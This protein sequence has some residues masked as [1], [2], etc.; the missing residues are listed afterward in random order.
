MKRT[1][2]PGASSAPAGAVD[3]LRPTWISCTG[4]RLA[5]RRFTPYSLQPRGEKPLMSAALPLTPPGVI[6]QE[7]R[8]PRAVRRGVIAG[9]VGNML[10]WYDFALFGFFAQQLGEHFFPAHT[11]P[12]RS[13]PRSAPSP[14]ASSCGPWAARCSAGSATATG[15]SRPHLVGARD[16]VPLVLHRPASHRRERSAS[17][18]PVLLVLLRMLQGIAVGGEYMASAVFLVEGSDPG[19]RGSWEA[20][21]RSAP[22]PASCS[23]PP[24]ARWSTRCCR[25]RRS[26][27]TA[28]GS[29]SSPASSWRSAGS[30]SGATTSN[31]CP[32]SRR[33]SRRSARRSARTGG[34]CS[35]WWGWWRGSASGFY[36]VVR[37]RRHLA[38]EVAGVPA[39]TALDVNTAAMVL[40]WSSIPAAGWASDRLGRRPVMA[41]AAGALAVLAY[42]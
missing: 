6:T 39:S 28:G 3:P 7:F 20:G 24:P 30:P 32:T 35:I 21:D 8:T 22:R 31:A 33:P 4:P 16:G 18:A 37:L 38:P 9:V 2:A 25:P 26:W 17:L 5:S 23:A 29:R 27:P 14:R 12:P 19:R 1:V 13:W 42:P 40:C 10:E 36:T 41:A 34:P 15:G 11:P